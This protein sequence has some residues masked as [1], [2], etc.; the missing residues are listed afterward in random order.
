MEGMVILSPFTYGL[1][2]VGIAVV[3]LAIGWFG[4][5][6]FVVAKRKFKEVKTNGFRRR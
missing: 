3:C 5:V 2:R 4:R 1:V 6:G